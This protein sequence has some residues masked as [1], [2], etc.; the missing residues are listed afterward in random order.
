LIALETPSSIPLLEV[1]SLTKWFPLKEG[2]LSPKRQIRAVDGVSFAIRPGETFGLVGESGC[3]KTTT[4]RLI[5]RLIEAS[6]GSI[7][8]MGDNVL[9]LKGS[10]LKEFR[11]NTQII[12]QDPFTSLDPRMTV[13]DLLE[14]PFKIHGVSRRDRT[15]EIEKLLEVVGLAPQYLSHY[16]HEFSGGQRQRI[17]IARALA[18][19][20]KFI[21]CDEPVSA[22]DVSIQSQILNLLSDLQ[23][24]YGIAYLFISHNL[25]VV[26]HISHRVA[27]MYLGRIV[28]IAPSDE[29][30]RNPAHPYTRLLL[31]SI[32]VPDPEVEDVKEMSTLEIE[33][34]ADDMRGC[35]FCARCPERADSICDSDDPRLM[36]ISK[37]HMVACHAQARNQSMRGMSC[38]IS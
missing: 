27:V 13:K 23:Q 21:V 2:V 1:K 16:P 7:T 8:F 12:F 33:S 29:L 4:G 11:R 30:Y 5:L 18:L 9:G 20:P 17:G 34:V 32:P 14:E 36:E 6:F 31:A 38:S 19:K 28:E 24:S 26:N 15:G 22:L 35:R 3:G 10:R 25:N 37:G